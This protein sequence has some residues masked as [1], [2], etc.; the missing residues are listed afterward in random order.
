VQPHVHPHDRP[1]L[2]RQR[3]RR[4]VVEAA[5]VGELPGDVAVAIELRQ[6]GLRRDDAQDHLA[7]FLNLPDRAGEREGRLASRSK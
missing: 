1:A 5:A 3:A 7:A 2:A 4:L 6:V